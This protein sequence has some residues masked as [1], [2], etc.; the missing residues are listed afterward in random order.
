MEEEQGTSNPGG[1]HS[2]ALDH[3]GP[4]IVNVDGTLQRIPNWDTMT[5]A[6]QKKAHRL[7]AARNKRRIQALEAQQTQQ[8]PTNE[9][10]GDS[11]V[12]DATSTMAIEDE[13]RPS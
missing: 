5:E 9:T 12:A 2:I 6:E 10:N 8:P 13:S 4:I 11:T 7:L 3:L 1:Q